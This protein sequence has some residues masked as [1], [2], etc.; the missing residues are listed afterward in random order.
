MEWGKSMVIILVFVILVSN[1]TASI[2]IATVQENWPLY[3]CNPLV[4]PFASTFSPTPTTAG[5]N[6]SYCVQDMM[7]S[8][9]PALTQP[10]SY[11]QT[12]TLELLGSLTTSTEKST[13]QTSKFSF[14]VSNMF[15]SIFDVVIGIM[16]EF[17]IITVKMMDAQGKIM[18]SMVA[19]MHI[20]TSVQYTFESMWA[21]IPGAM[22]RSFDSITVDNK[23]K[24]KK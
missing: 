20:L 1:I 22:V 17:N 12:M 5:E 7:M 16:A 15:S 11:V 14:S 23:K 24:K 13:A 10:L 9:G 2:G 21:G 8:F 3:R 4:M 18:G 6:F 19:V